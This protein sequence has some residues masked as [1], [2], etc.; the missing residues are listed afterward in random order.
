[1]NAARFASLIASSALVGS[2]IAL[3]P[4]AAAVE[5]SVAVNCGSG[6]VAEFSVSPGDTIVF[7]FADS[8]CSFFI[9]GMDQAAFQS[10]ID[11]NADL[12]GTGGTA[13]GDHGA[14]IVTYTAGPRGGVDTFTVVPPTRGWSI[15]EYRMYGSG[16]GNPPAPW[17]QAVGRASGATCPAGWNP[18]WAQWP[19]NNTGGFVCVREQT[20][21]T[22]LSGWVYKG[23]R[24]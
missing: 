17:L 13:I 20:W 15:N 9:S 7:S 18:S 23:S 4:P 10:Y 2:M 24:H 11:A 19:N 1:M 22:S 6:D 12:T 5:Q 14:M 8:S 21:D 3:A 16:G